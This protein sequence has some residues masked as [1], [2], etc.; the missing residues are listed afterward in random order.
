MPSFRGLIVFTCDSEVRGSSEDVHSGGVNQYA[1][2]DQFDFV[3]VEFRARCGGFET[4]RI[5]VETSERYARPFQRCR[6]GAI[7]R[8]F[9]RCRCFE[10]KS[11]ETD[12]DEV[13]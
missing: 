9:A 8:R 3:V 6:H 4:D 10:S 7:T 11:A 2:G 5:D 12:A 13:N 1:E